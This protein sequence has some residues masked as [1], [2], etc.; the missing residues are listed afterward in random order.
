MKLQRASIFS[1]AELTSED[2]AKHKISELEKVMNL[3]RSQLSLDKAC[4]LNL[5][6]VELS[7]RHM[8][9]YSLG[10]CRVLLSE[11]ESGKCSAEGA[12]LE[13]LSRRWVRDMGLF[14]KLVEDVRSVGKGL[15]TDYAI[16]LPTRIEEEYLP[17]FQFLLDNLKKQI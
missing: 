14:D 15:E 1:S 16:N 12:F 10:A 3:L 9:A 2:Q 7:F 13:A 5:T 17:W 11:P 8:Y 4:D 6:D